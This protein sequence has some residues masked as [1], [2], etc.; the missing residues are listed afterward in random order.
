[1]GVN[2]SEQESFW[3][4]GSFAVITDNTK[5]AMKW[6]IEELTK[7]G[8]K[9]YVVDL[10]GNPNKGHLQ[11]ISQ[12]PQGLDCAVI[13]VTKTN[14]ADAVTGL[15]KKGIR[16]IWLHWKTET[17]EVNNIFSKSEFQCITGKC[18]M[19][20]LGHG[21]NMHTIHR[22]IAKLMGKY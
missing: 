22:S 6:T 11:D 19:M 12:L 14:P 15:G 8:K 1:M 10:S 16:K 13:G 9:V 18:P 5:P 21:F 7:M 2:M 17:P 4:T 3:N 20:Y